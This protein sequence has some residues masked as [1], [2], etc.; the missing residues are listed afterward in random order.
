MQVAKLHHDYE[1]WQD[2]TISCAGLTLNKCDPL[3]CEIKAPTFCP[4]T[5]VITGLCSKIC[6]THLVSALGAAEAVPEWLYWNKQS[7]HF[8]SLTLQNLQNT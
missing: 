1:C 2:R 3:P 4:N 7:V 8:G 6:G 5:T